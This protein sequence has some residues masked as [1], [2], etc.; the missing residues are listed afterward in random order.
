MFISLIGMSGSGKSVWAK[1]LEREKGFRR[2]TCDE[3]I[4]KELTPEFSKSG[5]SVTEGLSYWMGQPYDERYARTSQI[6]LESE[7]QSLRNVLEEIKK[8]NK[9]DNAVVDTTGSVI[10][11]PQEL[12]KEL[13]ELT[14]I[15]YL[16]MPEN[17]MEKMIARYVADPKPVIWGDLYQPA[18]GETKEETLKRCYPGLLRYRAER[19]EKL[20]DIKLDYATRIDKKFTPDD[21]LRLVKSKND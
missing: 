19:Y 6:Y 10:Y 17:L 9:E 14:R 4:G 13:K 7:A 20:A 12:L 18:E 8:M 21:F 2:Y 1:T 11:L 5:Y 15:I 16:K 3:L